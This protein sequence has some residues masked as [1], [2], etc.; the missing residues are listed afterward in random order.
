[1]EKWISKAE[2]MLS[3]MNQV[4]E[5]WEHLSDEQQQILAEK[6]PFDQSFDEVTTNIKEWLD[7]VKK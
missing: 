1:M 7:H 2:V 5:E 6:Y 4:S 3:V